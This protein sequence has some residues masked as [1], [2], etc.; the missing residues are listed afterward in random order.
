ME[1]F[2]ANKL[3]VV[4]RLLLRKEVNVGGKTG[5]LRLASRS[6]DSRVARWQRN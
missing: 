5:S 4:E 3:V 2:L 1:E 6:A